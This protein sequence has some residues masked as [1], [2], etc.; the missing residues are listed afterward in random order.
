MLGEG[1]LLGAN[2][3]YDASRLYNKWYSSGGLGLEM[4]ATVGGDD[5][6][7]LNANWYANL[8]NKNALVNAFRNRG[9]S[10]D[11]EAGYS[12]A[13]FEHALDLRLKFAGYQLDVGSAVYGWRGG[14]DL[15]TK[16]GMFK[17][18]YEHGS[19]P[20]NGQ[21]N[22]VGGFVNVGFQL[23]NLLAGETPFAMPEPVFRSPR[24]LR[25]LLGLKVKRNW[26]QPASVILA[27]SNAGSTPSERC[28]DSLPGSR[29]DRASIRNPP[30]IHPLPSDEYTRKRIQT[31]PL[32]AGVDS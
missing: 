27:R 31:C 6:V 19:D 20:I 15:T 26:H 22:T 2:G 25:R 4:A 17:L 1:M 16:N 12:H 29:L 10:F 3:F 18:R 32:Y 8:F 24:D 30:I 28:V 9:G 21:Y 23:E 14:A 7:D 11:V 13:L 5:A